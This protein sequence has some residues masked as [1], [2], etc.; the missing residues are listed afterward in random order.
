M[1]TDTVS[2]QSLIYFDL[3]VNSKSMVKT[4]ILQLPA[5]EILV[6]QRLPVLN[7]L[8]VSDLN[9]YVTTVWAGPILPEFG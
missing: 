4:V 5:T 9:I 7:W 6:G 8:G 3:L 2:L 1:W